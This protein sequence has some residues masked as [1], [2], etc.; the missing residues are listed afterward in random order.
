M[1][2]KKKDTVKF[3]SLVHRKWVLGIVEFVGEA[4][5]IV[6]HDGTRYSLQNYQVSQAY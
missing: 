5:C 6:V 3:F 4:N 2:F 1:E